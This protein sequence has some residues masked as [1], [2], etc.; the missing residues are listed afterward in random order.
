MAILK[1]KVNIF[2][3]DIKP[4]AASYNSITAGSAR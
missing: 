2:C 1:H 3:A 4:Y